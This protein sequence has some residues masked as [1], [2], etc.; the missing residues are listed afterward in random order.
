MIKAA[1]VHDINSIRYD[2]EVLA[3]ARALHEQDPS[4]PTVEEIIEKSV[5]PIRE[6]YLAQFE[7]NT[8]VTVHRVGLNEGAFLKLLG[9]K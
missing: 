3:G 8:P 2:P 9:G 5:I 7:S 1:G 4:G 6:K